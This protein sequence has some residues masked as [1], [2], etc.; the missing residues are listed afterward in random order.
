MSRQRITQDEP[1]NNLDLQSFPAQ[2]LEPARVL[3]RAH[4]ATRDVGW[5]SSDLGGRFDLQLPRG[6]AYVADDVASAIRERLGIVALSGH[7]PSSDADDLAVTLLDNVSGR[8]AAVSTPASAAFG[9][10]TELTSMVPYTVPQAWACAF[11]EAGFVG[12]RYVPRYT[13]GPASAWAV[14]GEAGAHPIGRI[15]EVLDG[16]TACARA[17]FTVLPGPPLAGQLTQVEPPGKER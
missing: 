1:R 15:V 9:I 14:F 5:F 8:F 12:I 6:T 11:D 16:R 7:I 4:A 10:T 2:E 3:A 17:G 13:P